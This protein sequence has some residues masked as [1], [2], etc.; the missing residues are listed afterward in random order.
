MTG[1]IKSS[2]AQGEN[3]FPDKALFSI[4]FWQEN[5]KL[6]VVNGKSKT[7]KDTKI[8]L[9]NLTLYCKKFK[10]LR[11]NEIEWKV[12]KTA[13]KFKNPRLKE[14]HKNE[15][16]THHKYR[17]EI[18]RLNEKFPRPTICHPLSYEF[19]QYYQIC[20]ALYTLYT[21]FLSIL[22]TQWTAMGQHSWLPFHF[23][24]LWLQVFV[25]QQEI[26]LKTK[27]K[28]WGYQLD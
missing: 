21:V 20:E 27:Y 9:R 17:S 12:S 4:L 19:L 25:K 5:T 23:L 3:N 18:S 10:Y 28:L 24:Q 8:L 11:L 15:T 26:F 13:K 1:R 6:G 2:C 22:A 16:L 7:C 14:T